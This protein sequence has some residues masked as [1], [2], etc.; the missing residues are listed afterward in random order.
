MAAV[1]ALLNGS[2]PQGCVRMEIANQQGPVQ[3]EGFGS[4]RRVAVG[5][6]AIHRL[7]KKAGPKAEHPAEAYKRQEPKGEKGGTQH[8]SKLPE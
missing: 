1:T 4:Q 3:S 5:S 8:V 2:L 6:Q 7:F